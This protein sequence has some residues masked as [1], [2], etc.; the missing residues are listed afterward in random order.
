MKPTATTTA[1]AVIRP[2]HVSF[3]PLEERGGSGSRSGASAS[4]VRSSAIATSPTKAVL[5]LRGRD[6]RHGGSAGGGGAPGW[7]GCIAACVGAVRSGAASAVCGE[8]AGAESGSS[9][10]AFFGAYFTG[11]SFDGP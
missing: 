4:L 3:D 10:W 7:G 2:T 8:A 1:T 11:S 5:P 6:L 9:C